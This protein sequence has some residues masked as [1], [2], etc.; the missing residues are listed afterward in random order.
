MACDPWHIWPLWSG[1]VWVKEKPIKFWCRWHVWPLRSGWVWVKEEPIKL[2]C[3]SGY[4]WGGV[5]PQFFSLL[6]LGYEDT[7]WNFQHCHCEHIQNSW[8]HSCRPGHNDSWVTAVN[9]VHAIHVTAR[10]TD[11]RPVL[12]PCNASRS[13][14]RIIRVVWPSDITLSCQLLWCGICFD[15]NLLC[16][17]LNPLLMSWCCKVW[18]PPLGIFYVCVI[19]ARRRPMTEEACLVSF[20]HIVCWHYILLL[21]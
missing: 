10:L 9:T 5:H 11:Y 2:W 15:S 18:D 8:S 4:K 12:Q 13:A 20:L 7:Y 14:G 19:N 1:R 21:L 3:R 16:M 17:D 6:T